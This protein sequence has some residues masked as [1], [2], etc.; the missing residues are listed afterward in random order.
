VVSAVL[1]ETADVCDA[2]HPA[3]Q[4]VHHADPRGG[5]ASPGHIYRKTHVRD[6]LRL[7]PERLAEEVE[8]TRLLVNVDIVHNADTQAVRVRRLIGRLPADGRRAATHVVLRAAKVDVFTCE[9][10]LVRKCL[11]SSGVLLSPKVK[12]LPTDQDDVIG[13]LAKPL[14]DLDGVFDA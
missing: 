10:P 1:F 13:E 8:L 5:S 14:E 11:G 12:R 3:V 4:R 7:E 9:R 6:R 2:A